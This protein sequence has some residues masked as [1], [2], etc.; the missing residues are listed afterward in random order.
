MC[1]LERNEEILFAFRKRVNDWEPY[2]TWEH[3]GKWE[4][5]CKEI[6]QKIQVYKPDAIMEHYD[7]TRDQSTRT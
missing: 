6:L 4:E 3:K 7:E 1:S 5:A 2:D